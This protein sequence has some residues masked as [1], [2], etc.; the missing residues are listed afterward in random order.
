MD[1]PW[2]PRPKPEQ[3]DRLERRI[4]FEDYASNRAFL[5]LLN[6]F[7]EQQGR[8]PDIS[9][10]RTYVN[11]TLRAEELGTPL[12]AIDHAFAAAIDALVP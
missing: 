4:E 6:D 7:C 10:G 3:A 5:D 2:T 9:F 8:Y 1:Q 11:I 12:G